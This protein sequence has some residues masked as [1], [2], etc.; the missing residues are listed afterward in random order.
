MRQPSAHY[1][2][3]FIL[4]TSFLAGDI[5]ELI[6]ERK[7]I[8]EYDIVSCHAERII[9]VYYQ[10]KGGTEWHGPVTG[11][12]VCYRSRTVNRRNAFEIK[13]TIPTEND[14]PRY[15][16]ERHECS[17]LASQQNL[18][19]AP[20]RLEAQPIAI[21]RNYRIM[22]SLRHPHRGETRTCLHLDEYLVE[23][24]SELVEFVDDDITDARSLAEKLKSSTD[25]V[26]RFLL[27]ILFSKEK[28]ALTEYEQNGQ[29]QQLKSELAA[30]LNRVIKNGSIYRREV[31][32]S[33]DLSAE[34]WLL[35]AQ[36]LNG[37]DLMHR[38]RR[39][40]EDAYP[41]E[42]RRKNPV[43]FR[44]VEIVG[45]NLQGLMDLAEV[46]ANS[47]NLVQ[48]QTAKIQRVLP[49]ISS[50]GQRQKLWLDT[51]T[52]VDDAMALLLALRSPERCEV[53]AV[54][55]VGGNVSVEKVAINN[56]KIIQYAGVHP[57]PPL[58]TG[59]APISAR[60]DARNVHGAEG[61]GEINR[62]LTSFTP[63]EAAA[64]APTFKSM[65]DRL[66]E[67]EVVF[68]ATGPLTNVA[69]LVEMCPDS[70]RRLKQIVIMGGAFNEPG[71]REALPEFNVF[72]DPESARRVLDFCRQN[73]I[74]HTFVPLD[75]THR[76]VLKSDRVQQLKREGFKSADFIASLTEHYMQFYDRNQA[77]AGCP[78]HD[79][80]AV[81]FALWPE[82]FISD[83]FHV[84]I[85]PSNSGPF[86]GATSAD[87]RPTRLFRNRSKEVT[88]I[89]LRVDRDRFLNKI[90]EKLLKR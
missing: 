48:V 5:F 32:S 80:M 54:S 14:Y 36:T 13:R 28:K 42:I 2:F 17:N 25:A 59:W 62:F 3:K 69:H 82:F 29:W 61:I 19:E 23:P 74:K 89:V 43:V 57:S 21:I 88:G 26:S 64:F 46:L 90:E 83:N 24:P 65:I 53:V 72:S 20:A 67:K 33:A 49:G 27:G 34:T 86:S 56:A 10:E 12:S 73:T 75:V 22:L 6:R 44:E 30:F 41:K 31:F 55:A 70:V 50:Q 71:N 76:V 40:L 51:D 35:V 7:I 11:P 78:M 47:F 45:D 66:P 58:L 79:P 8:G 85:A 4:P 15:T 16:C 77:M 87:F 81:G 84:E 52:G 63:P 39:L 60:G 68:V 1:E 37:E 9:D 18:V 38:N